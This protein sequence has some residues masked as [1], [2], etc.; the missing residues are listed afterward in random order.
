MAMMTRPPLPRRARTGG[1]RY[2]AG[3]TRG[4]CHGPQ[5]GRCGRRGSR[6]C[7][8]P[9]SRCMAKPVTS[10]RTSDSP[11]HLGPNRARAA[12]VTTAGAAARGSAG[13][14]PSSAADGRR[15]KRR[16][17]RRPR[18]QALEARPNPPAIY[19]HSA[20][21]F[22]ERAQPLPTGLAR[23]PGHQLRSIRLGGSR[24]RRLR[25]RGCSRLCGSSCPL[26][27]CRSGLLL[28]R[29]RG[30]SRL[31]GSSCPLLP[32][33]SGLLLLLR[34][35]LL[36]LGT[37][38]LLL[39]GLLLLL[40]GLLLLLLLLRGSLL[41]FL[42]RNLLLLSSG[43]LLL[44]GGLLLRCGGLLFL[45]GRSLLLCYPNFLFPSLLL[46]RL[47]VHFHVLGVLLFVLLV[48]VLVWLLLLGCHVLP[49]GGSGLRRLGGLYVRI[50][51][52]VCGSVLEESRRRHLRLI[53]RALPTLLLA[54]ID[55]LLV[56]LFIRSLVLLVC[57]LEQALLVL[58]HGLPSFRSCRHRLSPFEARVAHAEALEVAKPPRH[59]LLGPIWV[60]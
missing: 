45:G 29:R 59:R 58:R 44:R 41:L 15:R 1:R 3:A 16:R 52:P 33:R 60:P 19:N 28:R 4:Q 51:C 53:R 25:L 9:A 24:L 13:P 43:L 36:L 42:R 7:S 2:G 55:V 32:C 40:G 12:G 6:Q 30:C 11:S 8:T 23:S 49:Q 39:G 57:L 20:L 48:L 21:P 18:W 5:H 34:R 50:L 35:R 46:P 38:L 10:G 26:L 22:E 27:P 17:R 47:L 31:C 37:G 56:L 54:G 14:S